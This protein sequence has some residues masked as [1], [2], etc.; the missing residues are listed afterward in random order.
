LISSKQRSQEQRANS[1]Q[2]DG[3]HRLYNAGSL[4]EVEIVQPSGM[5]NFVATV[6]TD[7]SMKNIVSIIRVTKIW[8]LRT[9][10]APNEFE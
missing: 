8:K 9:L 7:V 5:T 4:N 2:E 3:T 6:T 1:S 10:E